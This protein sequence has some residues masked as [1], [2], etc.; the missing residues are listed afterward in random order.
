MKYI[1][2]HETEPNCLYEKQDFKSAVELKLSKKRR[3]IFQKSHVQ[4]IRLSQKIYR[5]F[6]LKN[7]R[8]F[9]G[10]LVIYILLSGW[11]GH[12]QAKS[13]VYTLF[14]INCP[15]NRIASTLA[16]IIIS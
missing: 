13:V 1:N 12:W 8:F 3:K 10:A 14:P 2:K 4:M 11:Q 5:F 7:R 6:F 9:P 16:S 15:N